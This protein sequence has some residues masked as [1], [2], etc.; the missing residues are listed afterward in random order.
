MKKI[1]HGWY[2]VGA[3]SGLQFLQAGL[4]TQAFGAYVAV[5]QEERGWSKTALSGAAALQQ[6]E[7][8]ILGPILGWMIDRFGPQIWIRIGVVVFGIGL[9]LL[10]FTD[11][12]LTFYGAFIVIALGSSLC[13][14]FPVNVALINW[15][16][17]WR[18]R[19][20]SSMSIGLAL[21]GI[22]L[23]MLAW[24]MGA[25]GWRATAFG[26]GVVM[27]VVGLP[28]AFVM[29]RRPEDYGETVDGIPPAPPKEGVSSTPGATRD[30]TAREALRTPAFWLL[31]LGHGFAL[32]VVHA[33]S[34][35]SITHMNQGLGYSLAQAS[36]VYTVLTLSQLGGVFIGWLIGDRYDKRLISAACMLTHM[37]ALLLLTYA[38]NVAM[39][40]AFAVLHGAAWGLR[41]PFMQALRADYFGRSAI[42]M[43]LGL[44]FMIIVIGQIGGP[45]IAG[46]MADL[47]GNYR[48]GFTILALLAGLG[49]LFFVLAKRPRLPAAAAP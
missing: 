19:A 9:M 1:F 43:I 12:L 10:S 2:M 30:F 34:V 29:R 31:S 21:G 7:V 45:M 3:G 37:T 28:L 49:S 22:S 46:I 16:E 5:L 48:A 14:F 26:S 40:L 18:A 25:F 35:H 11:T 13:G 15:F 38:A 42:G 44:S 20:L 36:L 6:M 39:V 47:T 4:M 17:R 24:S 32:L 41:G 8:A 23:P 33:V 27:I